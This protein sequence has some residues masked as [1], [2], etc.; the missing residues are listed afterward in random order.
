MYTNC[1]EL[2]LNSET[3]N[4]GKKWELNEDEL[5]IKLLNENKSYEEIAKEFKRTVNS[6]KAR[7][8]DKIIFLEYNN[9]N[10]N[11]LAEKYKFNDILYLERIIKK[12]IAR[13]ERSKENSRITKKLFENET[14]EDY[15]IRM[16]EIKEKKLNKKIERKIV[17]TA[18]GEKYYELLLNIVERLERIEK[19]IDGYD[20]S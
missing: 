2:R 20:F 9:G 13:E 1:Q 8:I 17:K 4:A 7:I 12:R 18:G 6:I 19:K 16:Q 3:C 11:E 15:D 10:F 5:L 14:K